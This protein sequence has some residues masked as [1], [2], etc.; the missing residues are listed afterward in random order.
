MA[1][2]FRIQGA[3]ILPYSSVPYLF[4][5]EKTEERIFRPLAPSLLVTFHEL[6]NY[7]FYEVIYT[8][9]YLKKE[10]YQKLLPI[11]YK[12]GQETQ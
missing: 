5:G 2:A 9:V 10:K 11:T 4:I 8:F 7:L 1:K 6:F 3:F 12:I